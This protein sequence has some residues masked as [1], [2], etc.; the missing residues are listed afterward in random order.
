MYKIQMIE[1]GDEMTMWGTVEKYEHPL[2][3]LAD[4]G[5]IEDYTDK[6]IPGPI[7]NVTSPNFISAV[8][9]DR[10]A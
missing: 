8:V 2:I 7:I 3:K 10:S 1:G 5:P 4:V 6:T 9:E